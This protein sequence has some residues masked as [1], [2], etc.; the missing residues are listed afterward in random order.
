[1]TCYGSEQV[2]VCV[3]VCVP[4]LVVDLTVS[5]VHID[6]SPD[7]VALDDLESPSSPV[8]VGDDVIDITVCTV[9]Y[10]CV[11]STPGHVSD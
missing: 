10:M 6:T 3:C 7:V 2:Q 1:M 8:V 5:S 9:M 11:P 4:V